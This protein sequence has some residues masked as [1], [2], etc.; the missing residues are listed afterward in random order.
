MTIVLDTAT[1]CVKFASLFQNPLLEE[2][3]RVETADQRRNQ[4]AM[5]ARATSLCG[6]CPLRAECLSD[7]VV[8]HDVAGIVAGTTESQRREI[9]ARLGVE[10][11]P[12]ELDTYAGVNSGRSFDQEEIHRLRMANPTQPLS[13]IAARIGCSVS[14]VKRHLRRAE[15]K[16]TTVQPLKRPK[17]TK[18]EVMAVAAQVLHPATEVA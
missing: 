15:A 5:M 17:P 11:D 4:A 18:Q 9:R 13:A 7:A 2:D 3:T 8:H 16:G 14:T 10:V 1:P 6:S 12:I